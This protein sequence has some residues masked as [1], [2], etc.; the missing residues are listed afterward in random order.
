MPMRV[1]FSTNYV[2]TIEYYKRVSEISGRSLSYILSEELYRA[3][4]SHTKKPIPMIKDKLTQKK[5]I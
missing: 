5:T 1:T 2:S 4:Q 3:S